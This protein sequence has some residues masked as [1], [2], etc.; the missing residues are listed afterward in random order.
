[1]QSGT[2]KGVNAEPF[3]WHQ[4]NGCGHNSAERKVQM[5]KFVKILKAIGNWF[6]FALTGKGEVAKE[7]IDDGAIDYS[8]Q[9]RDRYG[10]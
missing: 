7:A 4:E 8:G 6:V 2:R 5:K 1:M 3:S 9:G 10:R